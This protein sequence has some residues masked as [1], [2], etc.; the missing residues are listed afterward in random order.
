MMTKARLLYTLGRIAQG[1]D[2]EKQHA[3]ADAAL[4]D[5]IGDADITAAYHASNPGW[6]A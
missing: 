1:T 2:G 3:D 5:Y 6:C 4:L